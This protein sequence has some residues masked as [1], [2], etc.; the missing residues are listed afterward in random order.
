MVCL[1]IS[2]LTAEICSK[3]DAMSLE[4][5]DG[6]FDFLFFSFLMLEKQKG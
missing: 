2:P 6:R 1:F 5:H 4:I 3:S